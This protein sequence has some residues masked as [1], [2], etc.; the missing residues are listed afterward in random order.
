MNVSDSSS[1]GTR[2]TNGSTSLKKPVPVSENSTNSVPSTVLKE[3]VTDSIVG[4]GG[5]ISNAEVTMSRLLFLN[6]N[7]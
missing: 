3:V 5:R 7:R 2:V 4:V 1:S 6:S